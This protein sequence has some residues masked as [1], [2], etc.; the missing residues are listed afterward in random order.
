MR[1]A[2]CLNSS[3]IN[4]L[5]QIADAYNFE[6]QKSSK[7]ALMQEIIAHF[8]DRR[9]ISK[10]FT[11]IREAVLREAVSQLMLDNRREFSREEVLAAVRRAGTDKEGDDL[12]WM[13][14]LLAEGWLFRLHAK[15][16]R[17][18]YFVPEDLRKSIRTCLTESLKQRVQVA[19]SQPIVYRDEGMALVRDTTVFLQF[20]AKHEVRITKDGTILKRQ[21]GQILS[22]FEIKEEPL[23]K[24]SWRFGYG[25]R[26]HDYPDRFALIYDYCHARELIVETAD[27]E[28]LLHQ[29]AQ[30]WIAREE[31]E[32]AVDVFRYWRLLYRRPIPKLKHCIAT[33]SQA[34]REDWVHVESMNALLAAY[35]NDYYFDKA[36]TVMEQRIYGMLVHQG[37]LAHG[38]LADGTAVVKVTALGRELL[39]EEK[40]ELGGSPSQEEAEEQLPRMPL[41]LQPN[42]D[43]LVPVEAFAQVERKLDEL[44]DLIRV[45]T[46]RVHRLTKSSVRRALNSGWTGE[47]VLQFLRDQTAGM[48]PGN[49][50]RMI[51]QWCQTEAI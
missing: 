51:E 34:A 35:V 11:G 44:T 24:V 2:E 23:G 3:D 30:Q 29:K 39:L 6:C 20:L 37:L 21:L 12:K 41:I 33:L 17:Q 26:F 36:P 22:L 43:L 46:M 13:N 25:R 5:R 19:A 28:L 40:G 50:E 8:N 10:S 18:F 4:T 45:D 14:R 31:K 16:G 48:V 32:R 38:Q 1:L 49:V 9:F 42:F 15:G 7:N 47:T 27:G